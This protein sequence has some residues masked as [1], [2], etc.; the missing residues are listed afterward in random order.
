MGQRIGCC[1]QRTTTLCPE[2]CSINS[3]TVTPSSCQATGSG[4]WRKSQNQTISLYV[5]HSKVQSRVKRVLPLP[6]QQRCASSCILT[7][8]RRLLWADLR[9]RLSSMF[10]A[11]SPLHVIITL[12]S[13]LI[14]PG[15]ARPPPPA[16]NV[17]LLFFSQT[18]S[19]PQADMTSYRCR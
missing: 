15:A 18:S 4:Q 1:L 17:F 16:Q 7:R 19:P 2:M 13:P 6:R 14:I 8:V 3:T 9:V 5:W 11:S 10:P 12:V